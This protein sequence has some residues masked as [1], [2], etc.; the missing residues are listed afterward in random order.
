MPRTR[1]AV[2]IPALL[3]LA[4]GGLTA[5]GSQSAEEPQATSTAARNAPTSGIRSQA[6][7]TTPSALDGTQPTSQPTQQPA[8]KPSG[9]PNGADG[10][11]EETTSSATPE[12]SG[13]CGTESAKKAV[14]DNLDNVPGVDDPSMWTI[15]DL[16]TYDPCAALS[17]VTLSG[18]GTGSSIRQ[19]MLFHDGDYLGTTTSTPIGF[20]P[21]TVRLSDSSIQVT[22]T[23][24]R[25]GESNADASGRAVSVY[26]WNPDTES[27]DHSGEWPPGIG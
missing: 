16:D 14:D 3:V 27:I 17:W 22:Y 11:D 19:Q 4:L 24:T 9:T 6:P 26:S 2:V 10:A 21:A 20:H 18:G 25:G 8:A 23:Y 5:C 15:D 1:H 7:T 13:S 12:P